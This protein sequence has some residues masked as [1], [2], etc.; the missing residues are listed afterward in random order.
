MKRYGAFQ[1]DGS[2]VV[3]LCDDC[4]GPNREEVTVLPSDEVISLNAI[5]LPYRHSH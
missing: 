2:L 4:S 3:F 1:S 5:N